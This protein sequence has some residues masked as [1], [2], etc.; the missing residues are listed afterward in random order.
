LVDVAHRAI[1]TSDSIMLFVPLAGPAK[2]RRPLPQDGRQEPTAESLPKDARK[3]N[4][5]RLDR[6]YT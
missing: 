4:V 6:K 3:R 5:F 1:A 2:T